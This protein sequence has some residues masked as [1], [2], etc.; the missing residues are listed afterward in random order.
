MKTSMDCKSTFTVNKD[1]FKKFRA[2]FGKKF[3]PGNHLADQ[4]LQYLEIS[5]IVLFVK[6]G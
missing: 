5:Q 4:S 2:M 6:R 3:G 1:L